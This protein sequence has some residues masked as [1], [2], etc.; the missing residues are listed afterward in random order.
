MDELAFLTLMLLINHRIPHVPLEFY[1]CRFL[2]EMKGNHTFFSEGAR[3]RPIKLRHMRITW[4][5]RPTRDGNRQY[6]GRDTI[7]WQVGLE[8]SPHEE[9][10]GRWAQWGGRPTGP[11]APLP[12]CSTWLSPIGLLCRFKE[13]YARLPAEER[14]APPYIYEGRGSILNHGGDGRS[15]SSLQAT[16]E[17]PSRCSSSSLVE[18]LGLEEFRYES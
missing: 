1:E 6:K 7:Q 4:I 8:N 10:E 17:N 9:R 11:W 12:S 18:V 2:L 3:R 15:P 14:V 13:E 5:G 16:L